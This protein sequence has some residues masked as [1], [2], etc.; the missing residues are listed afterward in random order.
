MTCVYPT[1]TRH[2]L[3]KDKLQAALEQ[4]LVN[5]VNISGVDINKAVRDPYY[6]VLLPFVAGLGPRKAN[7]FVKRINTAVS[8]IS[9]DRDW[10]E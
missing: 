4:T 1:A 7:G 5:I 3:P 8:V 9:V 6:R 10:G 2:Q